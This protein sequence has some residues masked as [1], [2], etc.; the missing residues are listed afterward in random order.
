MVFQECAAQKVPVPWGAGTDDHAARAGFL[1]VAEAKKVELATQVENPL[2]IATAA[3]KKFVH[4]IEVL[5][6]A[7]RRRQ[8]MAIFRSC[9]LLQAETQ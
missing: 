7:Q 4:R 6:R 9:E 1:P 3:I 8:I 2:N 5:G